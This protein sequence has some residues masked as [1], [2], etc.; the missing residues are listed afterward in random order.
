MSAVPC[1]PIHKRIRT[2]PS[3][4]WG[5]RSQGQRLHIVAGLRDKDH[6]HTRG[7]NI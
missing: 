5:E 1:S 4:A 6:P 7:E 2:I 3:H